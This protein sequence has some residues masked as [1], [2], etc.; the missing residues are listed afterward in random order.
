MYYDSD[1]A[2]YPI[3]RQS[4]IDYYIS[5]G[6]Y[7]ISWR[8]KKQLT[9]L[10][11]SAEAE[12]RAMAIAIS[13]SIWLRSLFSSLGVASEP[14]MKLYCDNHSAIHIS[15][16]TVFHEHSKHFDMDYHFARECIQSRQLFNNS[17][18]DLKFRFKLH[19]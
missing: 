14:P 6:G 15:A 19:F 12:C 1:W 2:S 5:L 4:T 17:Q 3:T 16:N 9:V 8:T 10:R 7:P 13:E 11:S 18:Y